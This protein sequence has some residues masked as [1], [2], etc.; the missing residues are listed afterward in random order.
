MKVKELEV[1]RARLGPGLRPGPRRQAR[2]GGRGSAR[3][4]GTHPCGWRGRPGQCAAFRPGG[5]R[6]SPGDPRTRRDADGRDQLASRGNWGRCGGD[7]LR[8]V[9]GTPCAAAAAPVGLPPG[10]A[11]A[12]LPPRNGESPG[13]PRR[14]YPVI[15]TALLTPPV[16]RACSRGP[17]LAVRPGAPKVRP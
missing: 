11:R 10:R 8:P 2:W 15:P 17:V 6:L 14:L 12:K 16:A 7:R 3:K 9:A 1:R 4:G 5:C 13:D